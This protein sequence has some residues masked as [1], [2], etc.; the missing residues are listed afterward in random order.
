MLEGQLARHEMEF[1]VDMMTIDLGSIVFTTFPGELASELGAIVKDSFDGT[2]KHPV[3]IGYA[4]DYQGY[5][6][7]EHTYGGTSYESYVTQM[8]KGWSEKMFEAYREQ[9]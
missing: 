2:G 6:V 1:T 7:A 8:P 9:L 3:I 5:F 4:N